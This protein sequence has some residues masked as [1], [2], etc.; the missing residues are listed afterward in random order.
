[1]EVLEAYKPFERVRIKRMETT[2]LKI[3]FLK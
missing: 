2:L 1:M 3:I